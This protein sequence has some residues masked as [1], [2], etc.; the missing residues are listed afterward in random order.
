MTAIQKIQD[1]TG[2][3]YTYV[4]LVALSSLIRSGIG[5]F[6]LIGTAISL[7]VGLGITWFLGSKLQGKSS[8]TR[9]LLLVVSVVGLVASTVSVFG[10]GKALLGD[11]SLSALLPLLWSASMVYLHYTSFKTLNDPAVKSYIG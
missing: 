1:L 6:S 10:L 9:T 11:F 8:F 3:W 2:R 5:V 4:F 7:L